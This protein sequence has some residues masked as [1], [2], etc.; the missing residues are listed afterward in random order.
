[1]WLMRHSDIHSPASCKAHLES[2]TVVLCLEIGHS[3]S[4]HPRLHEPKQAKKTQKVNQKWLVRDCA[5]QSIRRLEKVRKTG[6][7]SRSKYGLR[8]SRPDPHEV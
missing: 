1:M 2:R 7:S 8:L 6:F 5:I 3:A 4:M